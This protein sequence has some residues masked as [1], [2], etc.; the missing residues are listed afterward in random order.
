MTDFETQISEL[1]PLLT[2]EQLEAALDLLRLLTEGVGAD[3]P[4]G[5]EKA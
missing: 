1:L 4:Q 5:K 3:C 2:Q